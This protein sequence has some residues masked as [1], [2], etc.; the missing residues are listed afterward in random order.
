MVPPMINA[1]EENS[2]NNDN[3]LSYHAF[4]FET[5]QFYKKFSMISIKTFLCILS[6]EIFLKTQT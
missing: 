3:F 5:L 1:I 6:N 2:T 4:D